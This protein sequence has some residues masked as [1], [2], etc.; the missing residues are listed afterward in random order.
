MQF[1]ILRTLT[2]KGKE[3]ICTTYIYIFNYWNIP[4]YIYIHKKDS[5]QRMFPVPTHHIIHQLPFGVWRWSCLAVCTWNNKKKRA[6]HIQHS[7][8]DAASLFDAP[9]TIDDFNTKIGPNRASPKLAPQLEKHSH[10]WILRPIKVWT[11]G[12]QITIP[13]DP[14]S[15]SE[16]GSME[17][18]YC[19]WLKSCTTSDV[20]NPIN[21]GINYQP[22]PG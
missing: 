20:W 17:P 8:H 3:G 15:P 6:E 21:N 10:G 22:Q 9:P 11:F 19:W 12:K 7:N 13:R 2:N 1:E 16:N 14:G 5:K 18:K 4:I